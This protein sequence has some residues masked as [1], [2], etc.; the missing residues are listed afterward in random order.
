MKNDPVENLRSDIQKLHDCASEDDAI[1]FLVSRALTPIMR[2]NMFR[3]WC[4]ENHVQ[5]RRSAL[6]RL[7]KLRRRE[8]FR[9]FTW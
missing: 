9:S 6:E 2:E 3:V 1:A 4:R 7:K 8:M 5:V